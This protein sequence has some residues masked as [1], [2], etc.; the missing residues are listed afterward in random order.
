[1][2]GMP[3]IS[4]PI[5][6]PKAVFQKF[7]KLFCNE[8]LLILKNFNTSNINELFGYNENCIHFY[9]MCLMRIELTTFDFGSQHSIRLSYR[10][11][12]II[13]DYF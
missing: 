11:K 8:K 5:V 6:F 9:K 3:N 4:I 13:A 10:H 2:L 1:M 12:F 7:L